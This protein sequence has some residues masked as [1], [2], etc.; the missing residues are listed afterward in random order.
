[1]STTLEPES[2]TES[3]SANVGNAVSHVRQNFIACRI[4][5]KWFGTSK[6]LTTSQKSQAAESFGADGRAISAA[7]RLIDTKHECY[8]AL[9]SIKSQVNKYWRESSLPYPEP[10]IRLIRNDAV[11]EFNS[12][13]ISYR[14]E[15]GNAVLTLNDHYAELK[16]AARQRLGSLFDAAD[17]P[18]SL[19][20]EFE[21]NWDFPSVEAPD[22]LRRLSPEI[23]Q[24]ECE[25]VQ[26]QFTQ[27]VSL[28]EQMFQEQLT[29]LVE[30]LVERLSADKS[31]K[32]KTFR[33]STI[34]NLDDFFARFRQ[35][36]IGSNEELEQLVERAQSIVHGVEPQQIRDND[37]LR[38]QIAT[39][40]S[41]VQSSLDGLVVD[42]PRRNIIRANRN[43]NAED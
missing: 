20:D 11:D 30:R 6:T 34:T 38:Q 29:E 33:D 32:P 24:Q 10:G 3:I 2:A 5:F 36:N 16:E 22:Y 9:T 26:S 1:M 4:K 7:K 23:Y 18:S 13:L 37:S 31:G 41:V 28:A 12:S 25:R 42:R 40:M 17:Y 27:A 19:T 14:C 35:L 15:L 39:Q 8:R 43:N 21:V